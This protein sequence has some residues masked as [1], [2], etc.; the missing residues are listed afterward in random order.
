MDFEPYFKVHDLVSV[1]PKSSILGQMANLYMIF[2]V[3]VSI[4]RLVKIWNS[5][6]FPA[7]FRNSSLSSRRLSNLVLGTLS[8]RR[9]RPDDGN[10]KRDISF[11]TSLHMYNTLWPDVALKLRT[12]ERGVSRRDENLS[13]SC[14]CFDPFSVLLCYF[15][16]EPR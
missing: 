1:H 4:Y 2:Y 15:R 16:A 7:E 8:N 13:T 3:M 6:Q 5:L 11:E 10:R 9:R 14:V 12:W